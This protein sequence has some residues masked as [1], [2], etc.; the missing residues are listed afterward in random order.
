MSE[1]KEGTGTAPRTWP[2]ISGDIWKETESDKGNEGHPPKLGD[3]WRET[4][5][6]KGVQIYIGCIENPNNRQ[7]LKKKAVNFNQFFHKSLGRF[8]VAT[9][10]QQLQMLCFQLPLLPWVS[11]VPLKGPHLT[12]GGGNFQGDIKETRKKQKISA[13]WQ[14]WG[15]GFVTIP[16]SFT[17]CHHSSVA[18]T[19]NSSNT[20][21]SPSVPSLSS[22]SNELCDKSA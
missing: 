17:S 21:N 2:P 9:R 16:H 19:S 10:P 14:V 8:R 20:I 11:R 7:W 5:R 22:L 12:Q 1:T 18:S 13:L 3:K 6:D 4:K 15:Q